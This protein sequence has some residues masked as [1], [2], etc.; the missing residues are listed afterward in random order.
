MNAL[1]ATERDKAIALGYYYGRKGDPSERIG[2]LGVGVIPDSPDLATF[3]EWY[4]LGEN[5]ARNPD[6]LND[7]EV[8]EEDDDDVCRVHGCDERTDDG[9]RVGRLLRKP[10]RSRGAEVMSGRNDWWMT[11]P[12]MWN[13]EGTEAGKITGS[14][15][16]CTLESC[17]GIR[18]GV[19]W[20][21]GKTT[22]PC[23][24]GVS[25]RADRSLQIG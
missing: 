16:A 10:C 13:R 19:K 15:R 21:D 9:E 6:I 23:T 11:N 4:A 12:T 20:Q 24:K 8:L 2:Y 22:W 5:D 17:G 18:L 1:G 25:E 7:N 3:D 14:T